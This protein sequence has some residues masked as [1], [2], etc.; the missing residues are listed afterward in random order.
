VSA[1]NAFIPTELFSGLD[2]SSSLP[3]LSLPSLSSEDA[4]A[5]EEAAELDA[6]PGVAEGE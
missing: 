2:S 6:P 4:A 5:D 3:S 1:A